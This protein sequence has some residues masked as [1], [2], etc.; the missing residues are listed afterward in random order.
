MTD[1]N[2]F[3]ERFTERAL[4]LKEKHQGDHASYLVELAKVMM[5]TARN[6]DERRQAES[7]LEGMKMAQRLLRDARRS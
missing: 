1:R 6:D 2:F 5:S 7:L 4:E 3:L